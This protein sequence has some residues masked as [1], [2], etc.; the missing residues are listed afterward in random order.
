MFDFTFSILTYL[1]PNVSIGCP[2]SI[3]LRIGKLGWT[4]RISASVK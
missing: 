4:I 3:G 2:S 1:L